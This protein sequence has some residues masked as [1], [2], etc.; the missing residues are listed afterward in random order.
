MEL[1]NFF[2]RHF[3]IEDSADKKLKAKTLEQ[4][5]DSKIDS[6]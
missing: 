2:S 4:S 3:P 5:L 6:R 1:K